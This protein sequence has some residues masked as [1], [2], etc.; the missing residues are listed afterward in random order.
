MPE[1]MGISI[2]G[3]LVSST[4]NLL[5]IVAITPVVL[6]TRCPLP[7]SPWPQW[8]LALV[9]LSTQNPYPLAHAVLSPHV[10][11]RPLPL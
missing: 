11:L 5:N 8:P 9:A 1:L 2:L 4:L 10:A 7:R 3:L 6:S